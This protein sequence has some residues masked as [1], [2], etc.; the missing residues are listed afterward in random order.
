VAELVALLVSIH[1]VD[2]SDPHCLPYKS[3]L[4]SRRTVCL[5]LVVNKSLAKSLARIFICQPDETFHSTDLLFRVN[6]CTQFLHL[7]EQIIL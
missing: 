3:A 2:L 6:L 4:V 7:A 5:F 1:P